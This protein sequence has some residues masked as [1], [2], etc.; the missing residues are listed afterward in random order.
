MI[1]CRNIIIYIV[2]FA[3]T[4]CAPLSTTLFRSPAADSK[5]TDAIALPEVAS[6][7]GKLKVLM[8]IHQQLPELFSDAARFDVD[9]F[10]ILEEQAELQTILRQNPRYLELWEK[11]QYLDFHFEIATNADNKVITTKQ[12]K[13][14]AV[15]DWRENLK[16]EK[17]STISKLSGKI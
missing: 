14:S 3:V 13:Q 9:L 1:K 2:V 17:I 8:S 16:D 10:E 4:S 12:I 6:D 15:N 7:E 5:P 11:K